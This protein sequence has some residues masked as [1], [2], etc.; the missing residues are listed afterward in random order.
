M[1][2]TGM[3]KGEVV[4]SR[5]VLLLISF[6]LFTNVYAVSCQSTIKQIN[7][8]INQN[9]ASTL[10]AWIKLETLQTALGEAKKTELKNHDIEYQW[11]CKEDMSTLLNV[12][13]TKGEIIVSIHGTYSDETG[14]SRFEYD[15]EAKTKSA[16][17]ETYQQKVTGFI[18]HFNQYF[19]TNLKTAAE[20]QQASLAKALAFYKAVRQCVPGT[21][22]Y[23]M[24]DL[25][26][27][28][29]ITAVVQGEK[30]HLCVV[31]SKL[32]VPGKG[33]FSKSCQYTA[34][35]LTLFTDQEAEFI[36]N[37]NF[38][39]DSSNLTPMQQAEMKDCQFD[40]SPGQ[41]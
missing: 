18:G 6:L 41:K 12:V 4:M 29:F 37:G 28:V 3:N 40:V 24:V 36:G 19:K 10:P 25:P 1:I 26:G 14:A 16:T 31:S 39:Y 23:L 20:V 17:S 5:S 8:A 30:N 33:I 13:A 32:F 7:A 9:K 38:T 15:R 11:V 22:Q 34:A 21:Y 35:T 2:Y 27:T